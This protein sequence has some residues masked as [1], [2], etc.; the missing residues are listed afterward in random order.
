MSASWRAH[1]ATK[2]VQPLSNT[3]ASRHFAGAES[4][5]LA[6]AFLIFL[7][8]RKKRPPSP[9]L[10]PW[11]SEPCILRG[12]P[13]GSEFASNGAVWRKLLGLGGAC[14]FQATARAGQRIRLRRGYRRMR[15]EKW[16]GTAPCTVDNRRLVRLQ[17][18]FVCA[19]PMPG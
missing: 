9:F 4:K 8:R 12:L 18:L 19:R 1:P 11:G 16:S 13:V 7:K 6:L 15:L 14:T 2:M 10:P 5:I 17:R 3:H